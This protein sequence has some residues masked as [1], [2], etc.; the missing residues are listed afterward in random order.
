MRSIC[1]KQGMD[2]DGE[3]IDDFSVDRRDRTSEAGTSGSSSDEEDDEEEAHY[4]VDAKERMGEPSTS[5]RDY[6]SLPL[7]EMEMVVNSPKIINTLEVKQEVVEANLLDNNKRDF[8]K[9][10]PLENVA[11][12]FEETIYAEVLNRSLTCLVVSLTL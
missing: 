5:G 12:L 4:I 11:W 9:V 2:F 3:D 10:C 1:C 7:T 8:Q 6:Q